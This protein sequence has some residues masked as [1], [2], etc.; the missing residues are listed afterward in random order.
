M[1]S[2]RSTVEFNG[3]RY[4][5]NGI[6]TT[7]DIGCLLILGNTGLA[8]KVEDIHVLKDGS[9]RVIGAVIAHKTLEIVPIR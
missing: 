9:L 3:L 5:A 8:V 4:S 7:H 2:F 6:L 1:S